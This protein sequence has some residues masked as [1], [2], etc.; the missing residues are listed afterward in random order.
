MISLWPSVPPSS[1][2][3]EV[4][5]KTP[6]LATRMWGIDAARV[7]AAVVVVFIH[8]ASGPLTGVGPPAVIVS[9][10]EAL[11]WAV[12]F[13]LATSCYFL[14]R[15]LRRSPQP[16]VVLRDRIR[17]LLPPL[18]AWSSVYLVAKTVL[19]SV[20]GDDAGLRYVV[21]DPTRLLALGGAGVQLYY[22]PMLMVFVPVGW[23]VHT[24]TRRARWTSIALSIASIVLAW[25]ATHSHNSYN[26]S[27]ATAFTSATNPADMNNMARVLLVVTAW[28]IRLLPYL[29]IC[30]VL[31]DFDVIKKLRPW[32]APIGL[33]VV[34][35]L[36]VWARPVEASAPA[37]LLAAFALLLAGASVAT[38][39]H[40][41]TSRVVG[42]M[43]ELSFAVFL[44]HVAVLQAV[45]NVGKTVGLGNPNSPSV[46]F[47]LTCW[48]VTTVVSFAV[49]VPIHRLEFS[50]RWLLGE[51]A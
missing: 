11:R 47:V 16:A 4:K 17:R 1:H 39:G 35:S 30:A 21:D 23:F 29:S 10:R 31:I 3:G 32:T 7:L 28:A 51:G 50:R 14:M 45:Q 13:F 24:V 36:M 6:R 5:P 44:V 49:A 20:T 9:I 43:A 18:L 42:G 8:S 22:L 40:R 19:A 2:H 12:P 38:I 33:A 48:L 41:Q 15:A 26:I 34:A 27:S 46:G 37:E 25:W